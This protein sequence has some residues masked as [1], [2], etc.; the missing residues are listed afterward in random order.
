MAAIKRTA[1]AVWN[2]DLP[3][4][5]GKITTSSGVLKETPYSFKTRFEDGAGTNPEELIA[6]AHAACY[7]MAF[8]FTLSNK[9]YQPTSVETR[10]ICSLEPQPAGG[11]KIT[12][13]Q[14]E[15]Q[16]QVPDID[17]ATFKEIAKEAEAG[18]PVSNA[19]RAVEIEL[20]ATLR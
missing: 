17:V 1:S 8:A 18:C 16:A 3:S 19:L 12:K 2:G 6:A 20:E 4:G 9:G 10:A 5:N 13:M 15:S 14:L 7:S 11:F